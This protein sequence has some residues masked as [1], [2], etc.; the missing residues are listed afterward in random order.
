M[1][2][3]FQAYALQQIPCVSHEQQLR[4]TLLGEEE[5]KT[6]AMKKVVSQNTIN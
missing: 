2:C 3:S 4:A 1:C 6:N 5:M